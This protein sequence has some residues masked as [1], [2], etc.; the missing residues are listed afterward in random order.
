MTAI[1]TFADEGSSQTRYTATVARHWSVED[2]EAHEKMGFHTGWGIATDQTA[3]AGEDPLICYI[4][5]N[6]CLFSSGSSCCSPSPCPASAQGQTQ[7][8]RDLLDPR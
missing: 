2:R 8:G 6:A 1:I 7:G 5:T 4:V 3:G